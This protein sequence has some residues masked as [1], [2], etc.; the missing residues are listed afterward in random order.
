MQIVFRLRRDVERS[1]RGQCYEGNDPREHRVPVEDAIADTAGSR[2]DAEIGPERLKEVFVGS[3][4]DATYD[5]SESCPEEDTQQDARY[6]EDNVEEPTPDW[7]AHVR[8]QFDANAAK[9]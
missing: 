5:V 1:V 3:K 9:H 2:V 8:A 7:I 6:A 4:R